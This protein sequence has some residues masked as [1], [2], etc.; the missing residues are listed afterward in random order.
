MKRAHVTQAIS[1]GNE[2]VEAGSIVEVEDA[3]YARLYKQGA[4]EAIEVYE[5]KKRAD[6]IAKKAREDADKAV[7]KAN[8]EARKASEQADK[9]ARDAEAQHD[10]QRKIQRTTLG[11]SARG[12]MVAT[13][14]DVG[15]TVTKEPGG[16]EGVPREDP[17]RPGQQRPGSGEPPP[18][19]KMATTVDPSISHDAAH[20]GQSTTE[21]DKRR[22][23]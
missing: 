13:R 2:R 10:P 21:A 5:A 4:I 18:D 15:I 22:G 6:E 23:R 9:A 12:G 11:A 17:S 8:E 14:E 1:V 20:K 3:V 7:A 16:E 19:P